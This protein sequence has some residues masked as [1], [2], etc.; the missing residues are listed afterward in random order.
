MLHATATGAKPS[1]IVNLL[2]SGPNAPGSGFAVPELYRFSGCRF[3]T[4]L[5]GISRDDFLNQAKASNYVADYPFPL[6]R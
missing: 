3:G 5:L 4:E 6:V 2:V 1:D